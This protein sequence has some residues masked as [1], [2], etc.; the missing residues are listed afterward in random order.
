MGRPGPGHPFSVAHPTP[1][2]QQRLIIT[3][4]GTRLYA[5]SFGDPGA[6][7]LVLSD[8]LGCNGS[9]FAYLVPHFRR[10]MRVIRWNYRA[11]GQSE[12]PDD[13]ARMTVDDCVEDLF[14]VCDA[15]GIQRAVHLGY[16]MGVEVVLDAAHRRPERMVAMILACGSPGRLPDTFHGNTLMRSFLPL[17]YTLVTRYKGPMMR[18]AHRVVPTHLMYL[19]SSISEFD[20]RLVEWPDMRPYLDHISALDLEAGANLLA[21]AAEHDTRPYLAD[22]RVP[23]FVIGA[24]RDS[25]APYFLAE[26]MYETLPGAEMLGI[27]GATHSALLEQP[28][29][30]NLGIEEFLVRR[31]FLGEG[32]GG[33]RSG[34][35]R[36]CDSIGNRS[37]RA[38]APGGQ[39]AGMHNRLSLSSDR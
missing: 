12:V 16:S 13:P 27:R 29:L 28:D 38:G 8:G 32:Q 21:S 26:Q 4:D 19:V 24:Q 7:P 14:E 39:G 18:L 2:D 5:E 36:A 34:R 23:A 22:I 3:R 20:G 35:V 11:H 31:N 15:F 9:F 37:E 25:F 10:F 33:S 17:F 6:T 30:V 1:P